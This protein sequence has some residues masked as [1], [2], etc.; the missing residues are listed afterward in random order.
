MFAV[1][2]HPHPL[3]SLISLSIFMSMVEFKEEFK[4]EQCFV[5]S[6]TLKKIHSSAALFYGMVSGNNATDDSYGNSLHKLS[7]TIFI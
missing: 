3:T 2:L 5:L 7:H 4:L 6:F 1:V